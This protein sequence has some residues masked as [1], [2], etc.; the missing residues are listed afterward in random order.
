MPLPWV[1]G[2]PHVLAPDVEDRALSVKQL[3]ELRSF[4]RRLCN[5]RLIRFTEASKFAG[6]RRGEPIDWFEINL[7]NISDEVIRK[8][9][10][11]VLSDGGEFVDIDGAPQSAPANDKWCSWAEL[12]M[13]PGHRQKAMIMFSH[14]WGGAFRDFMAS[15][16]MLVRDKALSMETKIWIC[17]FANNQFGEDFGANLAECPFIRV[18]NVVSTTIMIVDRFQGS[19][20]RTWCGLELHHS[21]KKDN[22]LELYTSSGRV[23]SARVSSG[24]LVEAVKAWDMR[25]TEASEESYR[26]QILNY[27]AGVEE[28]AG[29]LTENGQLVLD[30]GRPQLDAPPDAQMLDE[31]QPRAGKPCEFA[32]ESALF[33]KRGSAFEDLNMMVRLEVMAKIGRERKK[34][35]CVVSDIISRAISFGQWRTF[36]KQARDAHSAESWHCLDW[37]TQTHH[38]R[39]WNEVLTHHVIQ[40]FVKPRTKWDARE[41]SYMELVSDGPQLPNFYVSHIWAF[42]FHVLAATL[43]YFAEAMALPDTSTLWIDMIALNQNNTEALEKW[44]NGHQSIFSQCEGLLACVGGGELVFARTWCLYEYDSFRDHGKPIYLGCD[45]GVLAST[46]PFPAGGWVF[47]TFDPRIARMLGKWTVESSRTKLPEDKVMIMER[48]RVSGGRSFASRLNMQLRRWGAGPALRDAAIHGLPED[49]EEIRNLC[50]VPGL[51]VNSASLRG[52]GGESPLHLAAAVG[53]VC[54]MLELLAGKADPDG[55]DDILERPLHYAAMAGQTAAVRLLLQHRAD[56]HAESSYRET[57][58]EVAEQSPA[59]FLPTVTTDGVVQVLRDAMTNSETT[60]AAPHALTKEVVMSII[61]GSG[62][63]AMTPRAF[64]DVMSSFVPMEELQGLLDAAAARNTG[65]LTLDTLV[66]FIYSD[67]PHP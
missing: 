39:I 49:L 2:G 8:V 28:T 30:Q 66:D 21:L 63:Q 25:A 41:C 60:N 19:L 40:A 43:D 22:D 3:T 67:L 26:R 15:V 54:A 59:S 62:T 20:T 37:P 33:R 50:R 13:K 7:Y 10:P 11:E 42:P 14:W 44:M 58:L 47:G 53:N 4:L 38:K 16:D 29:L 1:R 31:E 64:I 18:L 51:S 9:I 52:P 56:A 48:L 12:V 57:A 27:I 45:T 34:V 61:Q 6:D 65:P 17:T 55:E 32:Y 35:G 5:A 46:R 36:V 23:G 24:P